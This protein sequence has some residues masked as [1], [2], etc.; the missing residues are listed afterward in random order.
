MN[1]LG[2]AQQGLWQAIVVAALVVSHSSLALA[3]GPTVIESPAIALSERRAAEAFE[4]YTRKDYAAAVALYLN[5]YQAAPS[6]SILYNIAR[7]YD[8]K[9][10]DRPLAITFYRRYIADPGAYT[11]RVEL[12]N[13]RLTE[14]RKAE[15]VAAE[16]TEPISAL[17]ASNRK[18]ESLAAP[19]VGAPSVDRGNQKTWAIAVG[20]L[21]ALGLIAGGALALI[22]N[23]R[24]QQ[25][26]DQ[27][28]PSN[29]NLCS[30]A[31]VTLRS[32][33]QRFGALATGFGVAG[34]TLLAAGTVLYVTTPRDDRGAVAGLGVG[35]RGL[36]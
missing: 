14:L 11:E 12:A 6:G 21:G 34:A 26:K 20:S 15:L 9:L 32:D 2:C 16:Q 23:D 30:N 31:G 17:A 7:I 24:N 29:P 5:A 10:G 18:P 36:F 25:S 27:C 33:A 19:P 28:N 8:T 13:Q 35:F 4:A 3:E 1:R 22:A